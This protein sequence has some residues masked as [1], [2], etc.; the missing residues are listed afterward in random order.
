VRDGGVLQLGGAA[1]SGRAPPIAQYL[2]A[3][4]RI[5]VDLGTIRLRLC[6]FRREPCRPSRASYGGS[7]S[8]GVYSRRTILKRALHMS[9]GLALTSCPCARWLGGAPALAPGPA[10]RP[11]LPSGIQSGD[12]RDGSAIVWSRTDRPA[13]MLVDWSTSPD[14]R[15]A[16]R[17]GGPRALADSDFTA[18]LELLD[19]PAGEEI[20]Y[21]VQFRSLIDAGSLSE[22]LEGRFRTPPAGPRNLRFCF[23]GDEVGQG[24]GINPEWGGL[25]LYET[26]RNLEPDFFVHSGDQIYADI[27]LQEEVT[28]EGGA[29]WRNLVTPAKAK[30]AETLDEFRGNFAYNLLDEH[31]RRFLSQVPV[32]VQWDDHEVKNNWFPGESIEKDAR[33]RIVNASVL[34]ERARQAMFEYNPFR[35]ES[36]QT[37]R[38]YR[39]FSYGPSLEVFLL[40]ER[41]YRG[42]NGPNRERHLGDTSA[43]L[44]RPQLEWL[45]GA[46]LRSSATW[47]LLASDMPLSLVVPDLN[48]Y[49]PSGGYEAWANGDSGRPLG[50][51]LEIAELLGFVQRHAIH[52]LVW[53][54]ADVHYASAIHYHPDRAH[55][56]P[57]P[58]F[59][60]FVAGPI[61]AG[62]FGPN[63]LDRTFGPQIRFQSVSPGMLPNRPPSEGLQ[64][65]G[66][67]EI[68][69]ASEVLRVSLRDLS[70]AVLFAV[71]LEPV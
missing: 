71:D 19:L 37:T 13:E 16:T 15:R 29:T 66:L 34:A 46:L 23:S 21:R 48:P 39:S 11:Q 20:F 12:L 28:L 54:T 47:K 5:C 64:F 60:E 52:N 25:R 51:E 24:W 63:A 6:V 27:P 31:K 10:S 9:A 42:P 40:D 32:L 1:A 43:F 3:L 62:T 2:L 38:I 36:G 35:L 49:V 61:H 22:P 18:R 70:G 57:F 53:I 26:M 44:G 67:G 17:L 30:V 69:G 56:G 14:F 41:S 68:D 59:W 8:Q 45:K 50:R 4:R 7:V 58:P 55:F 33:Y 65:F